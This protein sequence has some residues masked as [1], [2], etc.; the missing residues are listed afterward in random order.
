MKF[1][2]HCVIQ[3]FRAPQGSQPRLLGSEVR[4]PVP[5]LPRPQCRGLWRA[6]TG[7]MICKGKT[8]WKTKKN[9]YPKSNHMALKKKTYRNKKHHQT[10]QT[11]CFC[12]SGQGRQSECL[13]SLSAK[14]INHIFRAE[15]NEASST[16]QRRHRFFFVTVLKNCVRCHRKVFLFCFLFFAFVFLSERL[17]MEKHINLFLVTHG[18][19]SRKKTRT[20]TL[21]HHQP[22]P[23]LRSAP[24]E[25]G[26]L[27]RLAFSGRG[28]ERPG[29]YPFFVGWKYL[30]N[31]LEFTTNFFHM[32]LEYL[33]KLWVEFIQC[34][35]IQF[36]NHRTIWS[37]AIGLSSLLF[38]YYRTPWPRIG[39]QGPLPRAQWTLSSI[40]S[41]GTK[42]E[43]K[44]SNNH[45]IKKP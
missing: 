27:S 31:V 42:S 7:V 32:R 30:Q 15:T 24:A 26:R 18:F 21:G 20:Q 2:I 35:H 13:A 11:P 8:L 37:T 12:G 14:G 19:F 9:K 29:V 40:L 23:P 17:Q 33:Q 3:L 28:L 41:V 16:F 34:H 36:L 5:H 45:T 39:V 25:A 1:V 43:K 38:G 10:I 4:H 6:G 44:T 22:L